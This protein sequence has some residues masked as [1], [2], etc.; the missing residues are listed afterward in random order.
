ML[1]TQGFCLHV[2]RLRQEQRA[3]KAMARTVG[4]YQGFWNGLP[5]AALKGQIVECH[6]P[7]D[8][9]FA[10]GNTQD[11]RIAAGHYPLAA[12]SGTKFRTLGYRHS[13]DPAAL[14][15]PGLLLK[16]TDERRAILIHPAKDYLWSVGC[17]NPASGLSDANSRI[18]YAD[19]RRRVIALI[20]FLRSKLQ[21][22]APRPAAEV[23]IEGEPA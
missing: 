8:N 15:R 11:R 14:P 4:E 19:S 9:S 2:R 5:V 17:L 18:D 3:G 20:D 1:P 13:E 22:G 16:G 12:H 21:P 6:G 7:G 10:V 23:W